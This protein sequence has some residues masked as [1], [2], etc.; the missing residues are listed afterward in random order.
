MKKT[1][2][3]LLTIG[4]GILVGSAMAQAILLLPSTKSLFYISNH[5]LTSKVVDS[6]EKEKN[7]TITSTWLIHTPQKFNDQDAFYGGFSTE[8]GKKYEYYADVR[9]GDLLNLTLVP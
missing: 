6:F 5:Q 8:S 9:T 1:M 2:L 3:S 4:E 7:E